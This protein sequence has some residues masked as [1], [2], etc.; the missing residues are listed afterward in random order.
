MVVPPMLSKPSL[1]NKSP[2]FYLL[3]LIGCVAVAWWIILQGNQLE[4]L[5]TKPSNFTTEQLTDS[6]ASIVVRKGFYQIIENT[7]HP[8][9]IFLIQVIAILLASRLMGIALRKIGQP[10][11]IGEIIAGILL[12]PSF[13]GAIMPD[14]MNGLFPPDSLKDLQLLSQIGLAFFMFIIGLELDLAVLQNKAKEAVV[15]SNIS[16]AFP[17]VLGVGLAYWLFVDFAPYNTS[18]LSF[19]LFIGIAMSITAFPVLARILREKNLNKT[20]VGTLTLTCAAADD[21]TAWIILAIVIALSKAGDLTSAL[22]T[23][24]LTSGYV[25]LMYYGVK[26]LLAKLAHRWTINDKPS[27]NFIALS[28]FTLLFS[29]YIAEVLGIHALFGSFLAGVIMPQNEKLKALI[30]EKIQ[31]V[32]LLVLLP[33]FFA[34]TG[35]KTQIGLLNSPTLWL[36]FLLI[37]F[38]A[39]LGKLG[40]SAL[41]AR[42]V[43][44]S[45][46]DALMIGTLM[47]TRGLME[48]VVLNIG[49]DLGILSPEIFAMF[50]LMALATTFMTAPLLDLIQKWK[51]TP[52]PLPNE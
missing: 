45:W 48:L 43:G 35:L 22:F 27:R 49:Y 9:S 6:Q 4:G 20:A 19:A 41:S 25:A 7:K 23:I 21:V 3:F 2:L 46:K 32:S 17:Y 13:L 11:V 15:I 50:V 37:F 39:L 51:S 33:V 26:P 42:F 52:Q 28:F 36:T 24:G 14:L 1:Y 44:Q 30:T 18:F 31:D 29:A 38:V 5:Q 8:L 34:L 10:A 12:G 47:N 40:G 16:I